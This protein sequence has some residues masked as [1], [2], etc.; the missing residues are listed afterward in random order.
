M[1]GVLFSAVAAGRTV[2][3]LA[4]NENIGPFFIPFGEFGSFPYICTILELKLPQ[5]AKPPYLK[6]QG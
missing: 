1:T 6:P 4:K 5:V 2:F 3:R